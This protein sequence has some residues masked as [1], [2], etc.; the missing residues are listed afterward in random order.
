M[1]TQY[2]QR[3]YNYDFQY[4]MIKNLLEKNYCFDT[5]LIDLTSMIDRTLSPSENWCIIKERLLL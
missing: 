2:M 1:T 4:N 3:G 5:S